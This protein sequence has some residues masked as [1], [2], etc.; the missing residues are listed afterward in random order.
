MLFVR[1]IASPNL[2][3]NAVDE[4]RRRFIAD[5]RLLACVSDEDVN[6]TFVS[7]GVADGELRAAVAGLAETIGAP[8]AAGR[9]FRLELQHPDAAKAVSDDAVRAVAVALHGALRSSIHI[10]RRS[11]PAARFSATRPMGWGPE[12]LALGDSAPALPFGGSESSGVSLEVGSPTVIVKARLVG[13]IDASRLKQ[14]AQAVGGP[15]SGFVEVG[16]YPIAAR[17]DGSALFVLELGDVRRSPLHRVL[18]VLEIEARRFGGRLGLG[19]LL[20]NAPL[21]VFL[22]ALALHMGLHVAPGQMIETHLSA[23]A[24]PS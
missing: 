1:L 21:E 8:Q 6:A 22:D 7:L 3:P 2:S 12:G 11:L 19:A 24:P 5:G 10:T 15:E 9:A 23:G 20:T 13:G 4:L 16:A 18:R 17:R 14:I